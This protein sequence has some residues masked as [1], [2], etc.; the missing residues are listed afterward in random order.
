MCWGFWEVISFAFLNKLDH[1]LLVAVVGG[2][3]AEASG[4]SC[5]AT[6]REARLR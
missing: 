3:K 6:L 5:F 4:S 1:S 2:G